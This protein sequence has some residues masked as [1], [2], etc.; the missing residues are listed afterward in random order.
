MGEAFVAGVAVGTVLVVLITAALG[1]SSAVFG[2]RVIA[3]GRRYWVRGDAGFQRW[4]QGETGRSI[5]YGRQM[6]L[7]LKEDGVELFVPHRVEPVWV[8]DYE[9]VAR[10][11]TEKFRSRS[12]PGTRAVR[13]T[14]DDQGS[15][16]VRPEKLWL[17]ARFAS[18]SLVDELAHDLAVRVRS[19]ESTA[20]AD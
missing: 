2:A 18:P 14:L 10:I 1:A 5:G 8:A 15:F 12:V 17:P 19:A 11:S 20:D 3:D 13:I 9:S 16:A 4:L 6:L 7:V